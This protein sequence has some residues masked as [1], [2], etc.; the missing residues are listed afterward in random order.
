MGPKSTYPSHTLVKHKI[1]IKYDAN[2]PGQS[3]KQLLESSGLCVWTCK[4]SC[5]PTPTIFQ[6]LS[7]SGPWMMV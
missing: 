2:Y 5:S 7:G 6:Q 3:L 1:I 4:T